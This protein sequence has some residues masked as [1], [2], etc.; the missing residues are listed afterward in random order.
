V[1]TIGRHDYW[2]TYYWE[3]DVKA[4]DHRATKKDNWAT[5]KDCLTSS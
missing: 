4:K 1:Q 5:K 2:A 3:K